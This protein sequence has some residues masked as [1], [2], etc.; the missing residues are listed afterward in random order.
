MNIIG[1]LSTLLIDFDLEKNMLLK[2]II[3][4]TI[5]ASNIIP[6]I[7]YSI[8]NF[9]DDTF[10]LRPCLIYFIFVGSFYLIGVLIFAM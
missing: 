7:H 10:T 4:G 1:F 2:P 9:N 3:F 5:G 8:S 6:I